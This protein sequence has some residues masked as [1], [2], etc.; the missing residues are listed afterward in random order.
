MEGGVGERTKVKPA[1][2]QIRLGP[3][4]H[5][6]NLQMEK[7]TSERER[8]KCGLTSSSTFLINHSSV[9][10]CRRDVPK[11]QHREAEHQQEIDEA[12]K[13]GVVKLLPPPC[14][15]NL[16]AGR[17]QCGSSIVSILCGRQ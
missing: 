3:C 10:T 11:H 2:I 12:V 15:R 17:F 13:E 8:E 5:K 14:A 6:A 9:A 4:S 16:R 1:Y 7:L